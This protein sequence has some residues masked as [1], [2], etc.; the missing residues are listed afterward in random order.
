MNPFQTANARMNTAS[1]QM[2]MDPRLLK[3]IAGI[4][5]AGQMAPLVGG[6]VDLAVGDAIKIMIYHDS[7]ATRTLSSDERT[8]F[9]GFKLL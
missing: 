2:H 4:G 5:I 6:T 7:G 9:Q 8:V 1:A 3:T